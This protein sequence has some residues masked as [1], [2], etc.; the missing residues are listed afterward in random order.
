MGGYANQIEA[1]H[2]FS[3]AFLGVALICMI[4]QEL[5][6]A[7]GLPIILLT[8]CSTALAAKGREHSDERGL[9]GVQL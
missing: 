3:R 4:D 5:H 9:Q 2:L 1:S 6:I 7:I 8:L